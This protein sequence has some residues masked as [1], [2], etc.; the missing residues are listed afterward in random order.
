MTV[1]DINSIIEKSI[2]NPIDNSE[3]DTSSIKI[4]FT[5][6]FCPQKRIEK[7]IL[8]NQFDR[9]FNDTLP[10][11]KNKDISV[12]NLECPLTTNNNP[13]RKSG[14]NLKAHP[15]TAAAL[16]FAGFDV[17][18][19]ANNHIL[20]H[21]DSALLETT[22]SCNNENIK[23]VGAGSNLQNASKTLYVKVKEK[24]VAFLNFTEHEHSI[25][26]DDRAGANPLDPILNHYQIIEAKKNADII[27]IIIHGGSEFYSLPSPRMVKTYRFYADLGANLIIGHHT[28][29]AS[30]FEIYK[31]V[32]IFYS[33]GN[34]VFDRESVIN[35]G[36][37]EGYLV[38]VSIFNTT[39]NNIELIPYFQNKEFEG[40]RLMK[41]KDKNDFLTKI[42]DC[43]I[44][45]KNKK[46]LLEAWENHCKAKQ[47]YYLKNIFRWNKF[48]RQLV[49]RKIVPLKYLINYENSLG[50]LN[51]IRCESHREILVDILS[52][53]T[54]HKL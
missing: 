50:L 15:K 20:D 1:L 51:I 3:R 29:I 17:A 7:L 6:D 21:G 41:E 46:L 40:I 11:L 5:G 30:G 34:F 13:I 42:K 35:S 28:H 39:I 27:I 53:L 38:K 10:I 37:Y 4:I 14:P 2:Y 36:W 44:I 24:I 32:P 43:S 52:S 9:I 54:S 31:G 49:K 19:L 33:L 22:N 16:R 8:D 25:A 23:T 47:F 48:V 18:C 26:T 45:I 12:T